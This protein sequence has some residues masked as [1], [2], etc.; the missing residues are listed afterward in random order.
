MRNFVCAVRTKIGNLILRCLLRCI[1]YFFVATLF[2]WNICYIISGLTFGL[3]INFAAY[4]AGEK[5]FLGGKSIERT[6]LNRHSG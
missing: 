5:V 6:S 4:M 2:L 1:V 3:A